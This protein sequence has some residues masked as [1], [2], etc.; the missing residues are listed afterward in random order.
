MKFYVVDTHIDIL[1]EKFGGSYEHF[2]QILNANVK[3]RKFLKNVNKV[4]QLILLPIS[5]IFC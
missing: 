4:K 1:Q 2:L 3:K 5:T